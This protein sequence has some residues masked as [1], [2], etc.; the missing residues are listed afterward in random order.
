VFEPAFRA[1]IVREGRVEHGGQQALQ[2]L[3]QLLLVAMEAVREKIEVLLAAQEDS[4][5]MIGEV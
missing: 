3:M 2:I 4:L 5:V 1:V